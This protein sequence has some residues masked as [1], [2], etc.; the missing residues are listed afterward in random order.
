M[1]KTLLLLITIFMLFLGIDAVQAKEKTINISSD[2]SV[3]QLLDAGTECDALFGDPNKTGSLAY[4]L[5]KILD[6][7][8]YAGIVLCIVLTIVD[9]GKALLADD[10]DLFKPLTKTAFTRMI[11]AVLLFFLP[12]IV[13]TL[14]LLID[15]Y[16]TC[17]LT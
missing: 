9:F 11:Y 10:K 12:A 4:Y 5:Q 6:I 1:K 13:K 8:K 16:G 15:V 3:I 17:G 14:L 2:S 7:V